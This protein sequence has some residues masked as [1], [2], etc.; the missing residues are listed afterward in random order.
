[1]IIKINKNLYFRGYCCHF[2]VDRNKDK[3]LKNSFIYEEKIPILYE[4]KII[5]GYT[6]QVREDSFGL[7]IEFKLFDTL[8][9][10][11]FQIPSKLSVGFKCLK[12]FYKK[13]IR[14]IVKAKILEI[15]LVKNPSQPTTYY[16]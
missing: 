2:L 4:H 13:N 3:F 1:M 8:N 5:I 12:Y 16:Y 10:I 15:S 7:Y 6:T 14:Y 11:D 9:K